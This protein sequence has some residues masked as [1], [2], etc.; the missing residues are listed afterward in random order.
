MWDVE[1]WGWRWSTRTGREAH[2]A[3]RGSQG[4]MDSVVV[5]GWMGSV[6]AYVS[7]EAVLSSLVHLS[8]CC[9]EVGQPV[10]HMKWGDLHQASGA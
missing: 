4:R 10:F 6:R 7:K 9:G 1:V 3:A 5:L 2:G 8:L